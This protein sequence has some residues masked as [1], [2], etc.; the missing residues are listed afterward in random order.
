MVLEI[1]HGVLKTI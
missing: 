1:Q